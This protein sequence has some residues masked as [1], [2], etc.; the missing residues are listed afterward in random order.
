M[1]LTAIKDYGKFIYIT[2]KGPPDR[3]NAGIPAMLSRITEKM[4]QKFPDLDAIE[5]TY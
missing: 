4:L 1:H 3:T 2:L 5:L